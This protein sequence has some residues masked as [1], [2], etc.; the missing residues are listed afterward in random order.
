[1]ASPQITFIQ[2]PGCHLCADAEKAVRQVCSEIGLELTVVHVDDGFAQFAEKVPVVMIDGRVHAYWH[3]S[4][5]AL[6]RAVHQKMTPAGPIRRLWE[7]FKT[8]FIG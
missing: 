6:R 3:I 5:A 1:M 4:E 2:R 7:G 8:S